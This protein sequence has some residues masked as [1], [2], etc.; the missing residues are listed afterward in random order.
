M[1]IQPMVASAVKASLASRIGNGET[2]KKQGGLRPT[3]KVVQRGTQRTRQQT[4]STRG[5][6]RGRGGGGRMQ[7]QRTSRLFFIF[8]Y[9]FFLILMFQLTEMD[10]KDR[11]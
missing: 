1:N 8:I 9:Q 3:G 4:T 6:R 10:K 7:S 2:F 11:P 5:A